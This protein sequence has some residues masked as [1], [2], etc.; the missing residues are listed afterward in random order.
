MTWCMFNPQGGKPGAKLTWMNGSTPIVSD[1]VQATS[2]NALNDKLWDTSLYLKLENP[3]RFD[4]Q[5]SFHCVVE[6]PAYK[7]TPM[8]LNHS[9]NVACK[10][11]IFRCYLVCTRSP[12][13]PLERNNKL[14]KSNHVSF[15]LRPVL[16]KNIEVGRSFSI[17]IIVTFE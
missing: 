3:T 13:P 1:M 11:S 6:H 2:P 12:L 7:D 10:S 16:S 9:V 17:L 8:Y 14:E 15:H 5:R 4:H